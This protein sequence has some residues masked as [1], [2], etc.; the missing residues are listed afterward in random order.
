MHEHLDGRFPASRSRALRVSTIVPVLY[1]EPQLAGTLARLARLRDRLDLE[2]VLVVDIPDPAQEESTRERT[3]PIAAAV[4]AIVLYRIGER[5]FGSAVREGFSKAQGD[6]FVPFMGDACDDSEDIPRLVDEIGKGFDVV[7]GSR[8]MRDGRIVGN[9]VKQRISRFYSSLVH[10]VGGVA[11]HDVSNAF[12]AYRRVVA[13]SVETVADS[14]DI[15]VE[16]TVKAAQA[17]FLIGEVP[18]VWTNRKQGN[19][20]FKFGHELTN[21]SR[22]FLLAAKARLRRNQR[23]RGGS[24]PYDG[25]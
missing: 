12:K 2:I 9:T 11:I 21:Y 24:E 18:T 22:W 23:A 4:D 1:G 25:A 16:L 15:S 20:K 19:S 7:A 6:I 5:G 13:E 8:Y 10:V 14:F 3:E 17:G